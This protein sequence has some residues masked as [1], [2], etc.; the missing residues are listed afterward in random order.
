MPTVDKRLYQ[1]SYFAI[2]LKANPQHPMTSQPNWLIIE[3][4]GGRLVTNLPEPLGETVCQQSSYKIVRRQILPESIELGRPEEV[5]DFVYEYSNQAIP[6]WAV[7][8][9]SSHEALSENIAT[10]NSL[11]A[12]FKFRGD[13]QGF[14]LE[15][16]T[17]VLNNILNPTP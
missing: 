1:A 4:M 2:P 10:V 12:M 6:T 13:L 9:L 3:S 14:V 11:L 15:V 17:N 8:P 16:D 5:T 7:H